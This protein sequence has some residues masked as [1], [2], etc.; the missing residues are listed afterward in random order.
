MNNRRHPWTK[1]PLVHFLVLGALLFLA[2]ALWSP[3]SGTAAGRRILVDDAL[4]DHLA[5]TFALTW[6]RRPTENEIAALVDDHVKEE[7]LYREAVALGLDEDDV[8][9][10]R[11]LRQK[12]EFLSEDVALMAEPSDAEL[13]AYLAA[14]PDDFRVAALVSFRHVYL[15]PE[16]RGA[17]LD[18]DAARILETLRRGA[19]ANDEDRES[20]ALGDPFLLPARFDQIAVSDVA[21]QLGAS[22]AAGLERQ[23]TNA[24]SGPLRSEYGLHLVLVTER[25]DARLPPFGEIRDAVEREWRA[26][27]R[28]EANEAFYA[29]LRERYIVEIEM[30]SDKGEK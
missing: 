25:V 19:T 15:S 10:R 26:E 5:E 4:V 7:I 14:H 6:Q 17:S 9:V 13:E 29:K 27:K 2:F 16:R 22:F 28:L 24:W 12:M 21:E 18:R 1:E 23:P 3:G 11:R 20:E 30:S 8:V